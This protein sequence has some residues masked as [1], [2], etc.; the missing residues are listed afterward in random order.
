MQRQPQECV[1]SSSPLRRR[2]IS[3]P[4]LALEGLSNEARAEILERLSP[5]R[6]PPLS[7]S[8]SAST[9]HLLSTLFPASVTTLLTAESATPTPNTPNGLQP[10]TTARHQNLSRSRS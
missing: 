4:K 8:S 6:Y 7:A 2:L 5:P 1:S 3:A 9:I 10:P